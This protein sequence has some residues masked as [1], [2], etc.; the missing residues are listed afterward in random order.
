[1]TILELLLGQIANFCPVVSRN[2]I[3]KNSTSLDN[4]WQSI[5]LH[6]GFQSTGAHFIDFAAIKFQADERP[7][8][9]Y[10]RIVAFIEDNL[11][12]PDSGITHNG[13]PVTEEEELSPSLENYAVLTWLQLIHE[14]LPKLVKQRYGPELRSKTLASIKP[15]ISQALDSLLEELQACEDAKVMRA[16]AN[17]FRNRSNPAQ[18]RARPPQNRRPTPKCPLC[19]EAGRPYSHY[20]SKCLH[21]PPDDRKF[22]ARARRITDICEQSD[23]DEPDE[24]LDHQPVNTSESA[25]VNRVQVQQSPCLYAFH[26]CDTVCITIDSGATGNMMKASYARFLGVNVTTTKQLAKQADGLSPLKVVGEVHTSFTCDGH[27][28][29]FEGLVVENLDSDILAGMPFMEV[30][31]IAIRPA[32]HEIHIGDTFTYKYGSLPK[33]DTHSVKRAQ[34]LRAPSTGATI[35]PGEFLEVALPDGLAGVSATFAIE[36]RSDLPAQHDWPEPTL[37][38]S[39]Q[40]KVRL[41]NTTDHPLVLKRNEHFCQVRQTSVSDNVGQSPYIA[42]KREAPVTYPKY[43]SDLVKVDPE[44][45][46][47]T[48]SRTELRKITREFDDVFSPSFKGYNGALGPF[49]GEVNMGPVLPPQRKG[50]LPQYS[51]NQLE[52][53]QRQFDELEEIGVFQRPEDVG[54][55]VEYLNPSFLVKKPN[56]GFRLVTAFA[57]V[58]RYAKPQ[59]SLLPDVDNTLRQIAQWKHIITTDL[60]KAFYQI[61]LSKASM[62]YCGTVTPF[63]G[64]RVYTRCAMGMPGSETA[65]EELMCRALGDL[66]VKGV[67][68][69]LADDLYCGGNSPEELLANWRD[70]LTALRKCGLN[71]SAAK[72]VIAPKEV[73]ILGW[74]W[75]CGS[76]R[77]SP[78]R[79]ATLSSCSRPTTVTGL[80]SFIG[81]Y[82]V[83]SRVLRDTAS[84]VAP[85]EEAIAGKTAKEPLNWTENLAGS[86]TKA[87]ASLNEHKVIHLP[88]VDDQLWI[89][90]DGSMK[91]HGLGATL[92]LSRNNK[93]LL[94]GFFSA[95]LRNRQ[96]TWLPCEIEALSIAS[97]IKY[98]APY[99]IQSPNTMYVF[100]LTASPA[101]RLMKSYAEASFQPVHAF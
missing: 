4:I 75:S 54:V 81:A 78:H 71:L 96:M 2:T 95:K 22:L 37:V 17:D 31:D 15:E 34:V 94:G 16:T 72:T 6:Y 55:N 23:S 10:Q 5:R 26:E 86:F 62:K 3:V 43:H 69:K 79:I 89:V 98:F 85:L 64:V 84:H 45:Q 48:E 57:D 60:T 41:T 53:L 30:N 100:S 93:V 27:V 82:R 42:T 76:I 99:I 56:G 12:K 28:L 50:R 38:T 47:D 35:W 92:Y 29:T 44:G 101:S 51:R 32:K 59:P 80:R 19:K 33:A 68:V 24:I 90:T 67:V 87:Q 49:K 40:G 46:L 73:S 13:A 21:L 58:G 7:E 11:L 20:L 63:R 97:A 70:L 14:G 36:P 91:M 65:L 9:L 1:M 61:P 18:S 66:L 25:S 39:V 74:L 88:R 52:E 77:A 8:D 83:L